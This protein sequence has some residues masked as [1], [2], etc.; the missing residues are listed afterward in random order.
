LSALTR[1]SENEGG[2]LLS[3]LEEALVTGATRGHVKGNQ[4]GRRPV[5]Q[6][7]LPKILSDW[8]RVLGSIPRKVSEMD[9]RATSQETASR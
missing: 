6:T 1:V 9:D 8:R 5:L 7:P 4:H 3:G 2:N